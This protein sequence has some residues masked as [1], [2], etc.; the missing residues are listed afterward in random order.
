MKMW[1][2]TEG[3]IRLEKLSDIKSHTVYVLVDSMINKN[4]KTF[5]DCMKKLKGFNDV[6]YEIVSEQLD[7]LYCKNIVSLLYSI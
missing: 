2:I 7:C 4:V 3:K 5:N 6:E 1:D